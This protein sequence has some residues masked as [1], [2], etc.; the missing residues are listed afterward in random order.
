MF[1]TLVLVLS[2]IGLWVVLPTTTHYVEGPPN[3]IRS[4][5]MILGDKLLEAVLT[6]KK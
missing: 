1:I 3:I 5:W 2:L 6:D 4:D